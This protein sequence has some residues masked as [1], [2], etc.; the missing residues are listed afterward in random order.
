M[1]IMSGTYLYMKYL[2]IDLGTYLLIYLSIKKLNTLLI[3][4]SIFRLSLKV[5]F[6]FSHAIESSIA[7]GVKQGSS[8]RDEESKGIIFIAQLDTTILFNGMIVLRRLHM[9][10]YKIS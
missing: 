4:R 1:P 10:G 2:P 9:A 7:P 8:S 3:R 5:L 6:L